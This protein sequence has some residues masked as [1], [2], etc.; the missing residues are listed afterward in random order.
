MKPVPFDG[1]W[2][3]AAASHR[4]F[5]THLA[6]GN[7]AELTSAL[8]GL[9]ATGCFWEC[10]PV[11]AA[12]ADAPFECVV[13]PT[14]AFDRHAPD[15]RPFRAQ[16]AGPGPGVRVFANLSGDATLVSPTETGPYAHL[17]AFLR[18]A[19]PALSTELWTRTAEAVLPRLARSERLWVSTHGL[20][21]L[22]LHVRLDR[23][24]KYYHHGPYRR[25]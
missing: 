6:A 25:G 18:A 8:L 13:L 1:G 10:A 16:L 9:D 23:V 2:R 19:P 7:G 4:A 11:S 20:G 3:L 5:W 14:R 17:L 15:A 21:V 12:N 24:P 22:W